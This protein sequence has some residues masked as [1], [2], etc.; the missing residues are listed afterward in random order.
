MRS[1]TNISNKRGAGDSGVFGR[2][3]K[4]VT[5][6]SALLAGLMAPA[7]AFAYTGLGQVLTTDKTSEINP[8]ISFAIDGF[9]ALGICIAGF[10]IWK[11]IE[12]SGDNSRTKI[13]F[14]ITLILVGSA[15]TVLPF[16]TGLGVG[17]LF[18]GSGTGNAPV[19]Q[20][21]TAG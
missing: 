7:C 17:T 18:A 3:G 1:I 10:G 15:L 12:A 21:V 5:A 13:S 20:P 11:L 9:F 6:G 2:I 8:I 19:I 14:P 4:I 16:V